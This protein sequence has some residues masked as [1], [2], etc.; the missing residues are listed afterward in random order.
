MASAP[1]TGKARR[2]GA[3]KLIET[4]APGKVVLSGE[5][6][7]LAGAPALVAALDRRVTCRLTLRRQ[8]GWEFLGTGHDMRQQMSLDD[9]LAS[10]ANTLAGI[11]PQVL[12]P[13]E[14]PPHVRVELDSSACYLNGI[15]LGIGSSAAVVVSFATALAALAGRSCTLSELLALHG[16]LQGGGSGL[17]VAASATGGVIRFTQGDALPVQL[18]TGLH[19]R[20]VFAGHGTSTSGMLAR[21]HAWRGG[22]TPAALRKLRFAAEEVATR[23]SAHATAADFLNALSTLTAALR[24]MDE[25]AGIGIFG[26]A[27]LAAARL[28]E[29]EGVV[30]KPCGAGGGDIGVAASDSLEPLEAFVA[31][32]SERGLTAVDVG[33][34]AEGA[35]EGTH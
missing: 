26:P 16:R 35:S 2:R 25:A 34:D 17:D 30:Y 5:Y 12:R 19:L 33:I 7:V 27:H 4:S 11:V 32:I 14:T 28:A 23:A 1:R 20:F 29:R 3:S 6:A 31:G 24:E 10:A 21:F 13:F 18:P 15:K 22:E 9:V 8:G